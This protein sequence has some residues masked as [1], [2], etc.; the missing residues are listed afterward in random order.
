MV[1]F[2]NCTLI[3]LRRADSIALVTETGTSL[4]LPLPMPTRPPAAPPRGG[5]GDGGG[6][7]PP[8]PR[9]LGRPHRP[10]LG[11]ARAHADA[12]VA[13][14]DDG[15]RGEAERASALHHLGDAAHRA[16]IFPQAVFG[17]LG[18]RAG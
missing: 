17:A 18:R 13:V 11:L 2:F 10:F 3:M 12:T 9:S 8:R 6:A 7:P 5:G 1:P 16:H 4:A 15:E 14:A